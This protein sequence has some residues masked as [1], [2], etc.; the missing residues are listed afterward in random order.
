MRFKLLASGFISMITCLFG[1]GNEWVCFEHSM[2]VLKAISINQEEQV[3]GWS[4]SDS[5]STEE[6]PDK[7]PFGKEVREGKGGYLFCPKCLHQ[8]PPGLE[9]DG[10]AKLN[11][12]PLY[13]T[14]QPG[15]LIRVNPE[16]PWVTNFFDEGYERTAI[17]FLLT[18]DVNCESIAMASLE[19]LFEGMHLPS[20]RYD[21][22]DKENIINM[23]K[24]IKIAI[25]L[26]AVDVIEIEKKTNSKCKL[27]PRDQGKYYFFDKFGSNML[28]RGI[29]ESTGFF[30]FNGLKE[31]VVV[32][33]C[34]T[35]VYGRSSYQT[36]VLY[37]LFKT[38]FPEGD[39][40]LAGDKEALIKYFCLKNVDMRFFLQNMSASY[41]D[42][43]FFSFTRIYE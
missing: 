43:Y 30:L 12:A 35:E 39:V 22:K 19:T 11:P 25:E 40:K 32:F 27:T 33:G 6:F 41:E 7:V 1:Y 2:T 37:C 24:K 21:E 9:V 28:Y 10:G 18:Y 15:V 17:D 8:P 4:D 16:N 26:D 29:N 14:I 38:G 23:A 42:F 3:S 36:R 5:G 20:Y 31:V 34:G 13:Y